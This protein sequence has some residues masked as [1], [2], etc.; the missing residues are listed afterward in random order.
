MIV[1]IDTC[2]G[3]RAYAGVVFSYHE[4]LE[5]GFRR[6]TDDEWL[7]QIVPN[8]PADVPWLEPVLGPR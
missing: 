7:E 5:P 6:L 8:P 3:P 1:S 4:H 2:S